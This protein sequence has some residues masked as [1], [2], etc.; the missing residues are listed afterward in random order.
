MSRHPD[1]DHE[2]ECDDCGE[3]DEM[4]TYC[5]DCGLNLCELCYGDLTWEICDDCRQKAIREKVK[6]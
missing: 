4:L 1:D 3:T 6:N 5:P 2:S